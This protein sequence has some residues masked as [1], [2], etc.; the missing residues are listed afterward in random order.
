[1]QDIGIDLGTATTI[2]YVHDDGVVLKEPS[3]VAINTKND[4]ILSVGE[5]AHKMIGKTPGHITA[6]YPLENGVISDYKV[7]QEMVKYFVKKI[8]KTTSVKPRIAICVPSGITNV[9]SQAVINAA[10]FAGARKVYLI[11]E[12]VAAAIGAGIDITKPNGNLIID[13]GGG[14][15][16][17]AVISLS[18]IAV[19]SSIRVAG[20]TFTRT[21]VKYMR[22]T[23]SILVGDKMAEQI[24]INI[25]SVFF[26]EDKQ[27]EVKGRNLLTGLPVKKMITR[28][29]IYPCIVEIAD[30][31]V[32][33]IPN[34]LSKT[35][36]E[37]ASDIFDNGIILTG[38]G[39]L[40]D[41]FDKYITSKTN[42]KC[43]IADNP[44]GCVAL[45]TGRAFDY[46]GKLVDGFVNPS[47]Y[48]H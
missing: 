8:C 43:V 2:V 38:G 48:Q 36:P 39:A 19:K 40:L 11:E 41:G 12:P 33:Q 26:D 7:A 4:S 32:D 24:K 46:L 18:G 23:Y 1:M 34:V 30:Q 45:G 35:P 13:I 44:E 3:V 17:L 25:G 14:T 6:M 20:N 5:D 15:T 27:F 37:L 10:V 28:K 29:E 22:D 42:T 16:D 9:E 21:I 47:T 31:I